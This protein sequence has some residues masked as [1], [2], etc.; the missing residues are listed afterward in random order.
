MAGIILLATKVQKFIGD[1]GITVVR[2]IMGLLLAAV[3][4]P[5]VRDQNQLLPK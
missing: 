3:P 5:N 4:L 1:H 2:K